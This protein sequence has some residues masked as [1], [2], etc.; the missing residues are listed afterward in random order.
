MR[1][2]ISDSIGAR[3]AG[4]IPGFPWVAPRR[5]GRLTP[6]ATAGCCCCC[7]CLARMP[8]S[9][10]GSSGRWGTS[11][12]C[13]FLVGLC[14]NANATRAAGRGRAL[15]RPLPRLQHKAGCCRRRRRRSRPR[16][17]PPV[18]RAAADRA[19]E[20]LPQHGM[21]ALVLR[22]AVDSTPA[23]AAA[24]R[25]A[26][27]PAAGASLCKAWATCPLL[28]PPRWSC[29]CHCCC[30]PC[31]CS[32]A[33]TLLT[34]PMIHTVG[35]QGP[36]RH[37]GAHSTASATPYRCRH[38]Q[39]STAGP[40]AAGDPRQ[41]PAAPGLPGLTRAAP[42]RRFGL[43]RRRAQAGARVRW[44][45]LVP[46]RARRLLALGRQQGSAGRATLRTAGAAAPVQQGVAA[47]AAQRQRAA[48]PAED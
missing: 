35:L 46:A 18:L 7:C 5:A 41:D 32:P 31:R 17:H 15:Q 3:S 16:P 8:T 30:R 24:V 27:D 47:A 39:P 13:V 10:T 12:S 45:A 48:A 22:L 37:V 28:T 20:F 21:R 26:A 14:S 36:P 4:G 23:A 40:A 1:L 34:Q 33:P 9:E 42:C 11:T 2:G 19:D 44:G 43:L 38:G 6:D 29:C 25:A